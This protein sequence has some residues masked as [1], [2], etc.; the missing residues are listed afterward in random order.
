MYSLKSEPFGSREL[1]IHF[2]KY[3]YGTFTSNCISLRDTIQ[4]KTLKFY[5]WSC[6]AFKARYLIYSKN[7][8]VLVSNYPIIFISLQICVFK[9]KK[10]FFEAVYLQS[11]KMLHLNKSCLFG[12]LIYLL[13][14]DTYMGKLHL[15]LHMLSVNLKLKTKIIKIKAASEDFQVKDLLT[16]L[17]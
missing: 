5:K 10:V 7:L 17:K 16:W 12:K 13:F 9:K 4:E 11:N 8:E 3:V 6:F 15:Q 1:N 2:F 14:I